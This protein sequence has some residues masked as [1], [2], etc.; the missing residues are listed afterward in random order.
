MTQTLSTAKAERRRHVPASLAPYAFRPGKSGNPGGKSTKYYQSQKICRDAS[1]EAARV[2]VE[3]L[4]SDDDRVR[5]M[6]AR[7]ITDRA[8]G[9]PRDFD[10]AA[11]KPEG[12]RFDPRAYTKEELARIE[13]A[14]LV[15]VDPARV[16][17]A[18]GQDVQEVIPPGDDGVSDDR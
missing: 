14:C 4:K 18:R 2:L 7:E 9:R 5:L 13:E 15:V 12:K 17:R 16:R 1:P 8:W 11:E 10:P 6:A 3:L